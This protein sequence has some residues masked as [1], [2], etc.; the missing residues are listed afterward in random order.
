MIIHWL[1]LRLTCLP[2]FATALAFLAICW[3]EG[4]TDALSLHSNGRAACVRDYLASTT[5]RYDDTKEN[6]AHD[7]PFAHQTALADGVLI[8]ASEGRGLGVFAAL[9][10]PKGAWFGEYQGELMTKE[11][12][13]TR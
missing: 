7:I 1:L 4:R 8:Q 9:P 2:S 3:V 10:I 12:V 13:E 11:Q 5:H 6:I